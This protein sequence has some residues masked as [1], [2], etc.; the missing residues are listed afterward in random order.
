MRAALPAGTAD[1]IGAWTERLARRDRLAAG[2]PGTLERETERTLGLLIGTAAR[3]EF[4]HGLVQSSPTLSAQWEKWLAHPVGQPP[5]KVLVRLVRYVSR[6]AAKTSPNSTFTAI[7]TGAWTSGGDGVLV[8]APLPP[9]RCLIEPDGTLMAD[10]AAAVAADAELRPALRVRA[11]PSLTRVGDRVMVLGRRPLEDIASVAALPGVEACLRALDGDRPALGEL[12][13]RLGAGTDGGKVRAFVD[14]LAELGVIE[15]HLPVDDQERDKFGALA[16][17]LRQHGGARWAPAAAASA[18]LSAALTA[19]GDA[20]AVAGHRARLRAV[21]AA[22]T[23]LRASA[24]L[25]PDPEGRS[26]SLHEYAVFPGPV[27]TAALPAWQDP[28]ASLEL[29]RRWMAPHDTALPLRLALGAYGN[30]RYPAGDPVPFLVFHRALLADLAGGGG[31]P[32]DD[33]RTLLAL[34]GTGRGAATWRS[35]ALRDLAA[36]RARSVAA[37]LGTPPGADG[38]ARPDPDLPA[39]DAGLPSW[40]VPA[41]SVAWFVQPD[42][43]RLV[44]NCAMSGHGRGRDRSL[45]LIAHG[46]GDLPPTAAPPTEALV[47]DSSGDFGHSLNLRR[48]DGGHE[49]D[50]PFTVHSPDTAR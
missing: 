13:A 39:G 26:A 46:G 4:R 24:G 50:Y 34:G 45:Y 30:S 12:Y 48:A 33:L 41:G 36:L 3:P 22:V 16:R 42:G 20:G 11:N 8:L 38:V 6:A 27:A 23:E 37:L 2:L 44:L 9:A 31:G 47:A 18:R 17:W 43:P 49:L 40:A 15:P 35:A 32:L 7:G 10:L 19:P 5:R 28:L 25:V 29:I 14:R 1:R 21:G